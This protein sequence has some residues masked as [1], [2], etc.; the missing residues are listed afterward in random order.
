MKFLGTG[1]V[2]KSQ[3]AIVTNKRPRVALNQAVVVPFIS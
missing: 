2:T 1:T 3:I